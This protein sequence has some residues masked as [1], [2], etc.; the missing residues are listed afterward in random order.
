V[1]LTS[2]TKVLTQ[3]GLLQSLI[4]SIAIVGFTGAMICLLAGMKSLVEKHL[5]RPKRTEH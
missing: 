4:A 5:V 1:D 2:V 3:I